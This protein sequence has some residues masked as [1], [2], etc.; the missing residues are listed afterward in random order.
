MTADRK[1]LITTNDGFAINMLA[2]NMVIAGGG[3]LIAT[4]QARED[5]DKHTTLG[6]WAP[7]TWV[8]VSQLD[9]L[10]NPIFRNPHEQTCG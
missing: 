5:D 2:A 1:W 6:A 9:D 8:S 10:G 3:T 4:G 7:S